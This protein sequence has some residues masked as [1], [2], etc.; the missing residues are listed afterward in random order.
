MIALSVGDSVRWLALMATA[1]AAGFFL[2]NTL[3]DVI[4]GMLLRREGTFA[5]GDAVSVGDTAGRIIR[6]GWCTTEIRTAIG[7]SQVLNSA[8]VEN[9]VCR[10]AAGTPVRTLQFSVI[11]RRPIDPEH[12]RQVLLKVTGRHA[13]IRTN[14]SPEVFLERISVNALRFQLVAVAALDG[15]SDSEVAPELASLLGEEFAELGIDA[16]VLFKSGD[17]FAVEEERGGGAS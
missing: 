10:F 13:A 6:I 17:F 12:V 9:T 4:A 2:R 7:T 8:L 3:A 11:V 14:P 1:L 16:V 5:V 15:C